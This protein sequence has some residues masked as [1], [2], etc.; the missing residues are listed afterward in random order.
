MPMPIVN[1]KPKAYPATIFFLLTG[2]AMILGFHYVEKLVSDLFEENDEW[3]II[4]WAL[5]VA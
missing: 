3:K 2:T 4:R 5:S 1:R